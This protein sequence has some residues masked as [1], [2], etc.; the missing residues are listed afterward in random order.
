MCIY[1][2]QSDPIAG[3][4]KHPFLELLVL[5]IIYNDFPHFHVCLDYKH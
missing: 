3:K 5:S 2:N 1:I 4:K